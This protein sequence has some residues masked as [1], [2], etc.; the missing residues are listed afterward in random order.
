[1]TWRFA[2]YP[3]CC[4]SDGVAAWEAQM[5]P[6]A[7]DPAVVAAQYREAIA[8]WCAQGWPHAQV[9]SG[10][11]EGGNGSTT[12]VALAEVSVRLG[13]PMPGTR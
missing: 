2:R 12:T 10:L 5:Q 9:S 13:G 1:M 6:R 8:S 11:S 7:M 3:G 4:A